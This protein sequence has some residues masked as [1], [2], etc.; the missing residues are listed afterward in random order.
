[1]IFS[2]KFRRSS[3]FHKKKSY[4]R[5]KQKFNTEGKKN[6]HN[7][8]KNFDINVD[9]QKTDEDQIQASY[10]EGFVSVDEYAKFYKMQ[11]SW[12]LYD[13]KNGNI[14]ARHFKGSMLLYSPDAYNKKITSDHKKTKLNAPKDLNNKKITT[15][16]SKQPQKHSLD[17]SSVSWPSSAHQTGAKIQQKIKKNTTKDF[18]AEDADNYTKNSSIVIQ[19]IIGASSGLENFELNYDNHPLTSKN[20][21]ANANN[22]AT[23]TKK[24]NDKLSQAIIQ[25][26]NSHQDTNYIIFEKTL[27]AI[28]NNN[29]L[30][31]E[32][33]KKL[34]EQ[35]LSIK[36]NA[37]SLLDQLKAL[38]DVQKKLIDFTEVSTEKIKNTADDVVSSK[39][40]IIEL[41]D[42]Q[43]NELNKKLLVLN[44]ELAQIKKQLQIKNRMLEDYQQLNELIN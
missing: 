2:Y 29:K 10:V 21:F 35:S 12:V 9:N 3:K 24:N 20:F 23:E 27:N 32:L 40:Q 25:R 22:A 26:I 44:E 5:D 16:P 15:S 33:A 42:Q 11:R 38:S 18:A 34:D 13:I 8:K 28:E 4:E 17:A 1:M 39:N 19:D 7:P 6:K 14:L 37:I 41:K 30:Y 36:S 43:I 31:I